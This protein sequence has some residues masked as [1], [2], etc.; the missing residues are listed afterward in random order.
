MQYYYVLRARTY[1][2]AR[3]IVVPPDTVRVRLVRRKYEEEVAGGVGPFDVVSCLMGSSMFD[4]GPHSIYASRQD[5]GVSYRRLMRSVMKE[6][7]DKD[8]IL[9]LVI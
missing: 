5:Q 7:V 6:N 8:A 3:T 2:Q 9:T 4:G 1:K